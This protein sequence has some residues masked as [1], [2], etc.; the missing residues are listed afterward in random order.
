MQNQKSKILRIG[1]WLRT[2]QNLLLSAFFLTACSD[3]NLPKVQALGGFRILGL[4]ASQP[5]LNSA[6]LPSTIT[7][8]P[9]ISDLGSGGRDITVSGSACID[10]GVSL[11]AS[12][13]CDNIPGK[14]DLAP[15]TITPTATTNNSQLFGTPSLTGALPPISVTVPAG[16]LSGRNSVDQ[17]NGVSFLVVLKLTAGNSTISAYKRIVV[18]TKTTVN[19]NP[20]FSG[21][22]ANGVALT[23]LPSAAVQLTSLASA[24]STFEYKDSSGNLKTQSKTLVV[25]YFISDGELKKSKTDPSTQNQWIP[26]STAPSGRPT[27]IVAV[28]YDS[29]G[30]MSYQITD[31]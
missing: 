13:N 24:A 3:S 2:F 5:E 22:L 11:G 28:V 23:S 30:G 19:T 8:T 12:P 4:Q 25:S 16:I 17:F 20:T 27:T 9:V 14:I 15:Q 10:P 7:I 31:L 18:S 29:L 26:P 1:F 21:I 6:S